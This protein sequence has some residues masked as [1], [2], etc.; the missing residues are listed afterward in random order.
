MGLLEEEW[1]TCIL[2]IFERSLWFLLHW[3]ASKRKWVL[4]SFN[5]SRK[6]CRG[7]LASSRSPS[8]DPRRAHLRHLTQ[9]QIS[10]LSSLRVNHF[11]GSL[12]LGH[13]WC[14]RRYGLTIGLISRMGLLVMGL[15]Q[16]KLR[17]LEKVVI[18]AR[19]A[20]ISIVV[21]LKSNRV[22]RL[23]AEEIF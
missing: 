5:L 20:V 13:L 19:S 7:S 14:H 4:S 11:W 18:L 9:L 23:P 15:L 22:C 1:R 8:I 6:S 10:R 3:I 17:A 16:R 21:P 2:T 12:G